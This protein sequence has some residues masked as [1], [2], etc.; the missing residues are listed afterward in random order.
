[1][2]KTKFPIIVLHNVVSAKICTEFVK[3]AAGMGFKT[4]IITHAQ[5]SA[6]QRGLPAAQKIAMQNDIN[7]LSLANLD[8]IKELIQ[9]EL[10]LVVAP[11]PYGKINLE[12]KFVSSLEGKRWVAVFGG[13]DPGLSRKDLEKGDKVVQVP[14]GD[15][16]SIGTLT[17]G[18]ALLTGKFAFN[19]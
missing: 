16:G 5:G 8:D 17:L 1:M 13:N 7:F 15:I 10:M 11:P 9:P 3:I 6:A 18:L 12:A 14:A 4:L 2:A 19:L